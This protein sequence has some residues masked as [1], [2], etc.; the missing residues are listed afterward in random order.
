MKSL[1]FSIILTTTLLSCN[2]QDCSKLPQIFQTYQDAKQIISVTNFKI[3]ENL[4]T[5]Q[6]SWIRSAQFFS[7]DGEKGFMIFKTDRQEY[8]HQ[9]L[10]IGIWNSFKRATSFGSFYNANIKNKYQL[11]LRQ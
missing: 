10:P 11:K 6:S 9:D 3:K 7:C 8:I 2:G 5:F 4:N 1:F